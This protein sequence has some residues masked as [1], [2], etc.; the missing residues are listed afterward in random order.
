M[1]VETVVSGVTGTAQGEIGYFR[2]ALRELLSVESVTRVEAVAGTTDHVV[3]W[4]YR[5][6]IAVAVSG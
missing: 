6:V 3:L 1:C 5:D 2:V 4:G